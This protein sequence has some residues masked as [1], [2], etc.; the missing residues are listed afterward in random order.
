MRTILL[1]LPICIL[2]LLCFACENRQVDIRNKELIHIYLDSLKRENLII[3]NMHKH[4]FLKLETTDENLM[5]YIEKMEF[6]ENEGKIFIK[7][8]NSRIFVFDIN[9]SFLNSIG[10]IGPGPDEHHTIT[11]FYLDRR[12][13]RVNIIDIFRGVIFSYSYSG[14]LLDRMRICDRIFDNFSQVHLLEDGALL[15][16]RGNSPQSL[17]NFSLVRGRSFNREVNKIPYQ[18]IGKNRSFFSRTNRR[19]AQSKNRTLMLE[20][21]S[22]TIYRYDVRTRS[23]LPEMVFK[24]RFRPMTIGDVGRRELFTGMDAMRVAINRNLSTGISGLTMTERHLH[25]IFRDGDRGVFRV[26]WDKETNT[27]SVSER[28]IENNLNPEGLLVDIFSTIHATT[29][30]A[31]VGVLYPGD[32]PLCFFLDYWRDYQPAREVLEVTHEDDNPILVFFYFE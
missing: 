14:E 22:D 9:G 2:L 28:F 15:L 26:F 23:I 29:S 19:V 3:K 6:D 20:M 27:G 12:N 30:D 17:Y 24:G 8:S 25:F 7:D 18:F 31:F 5:A 1:F 16:L 10:Q 13:R 21:M 32:F 4:R 11:D